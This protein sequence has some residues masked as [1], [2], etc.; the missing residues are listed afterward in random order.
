MVT[1]NERLEDGV[2]VSVFVPSMEEVEALL[3]SSAVEADEVDKG[4]ALDVTCCDVGLEVGVETAWELVSV[5]PATAL[6]AVA[7]LLQSEVYGPNRFCKYVLE[8]PLLDV[9]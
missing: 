2:E 1:I 4:A 5:E 7:K 3:V 9:A 8:D 6:T